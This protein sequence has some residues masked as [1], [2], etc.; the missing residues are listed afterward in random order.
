MASTNVSMPI[1]QIM[2]LNLL[3]ML[4][5][6]LILVSFATLLLA[7]NQFRNMCKY[8]FYLLDINVMLIARK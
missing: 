2:V 4:K 1:N 5:K 7:T 8:C 3:F 6:S